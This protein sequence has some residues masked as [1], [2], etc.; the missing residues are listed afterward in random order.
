MR[1]ALKAHESMWAAPYWTAKKLPPQI[2]AM[3]TRRRSVV[4]KPAPS[5]RATV[6]VATAGVG[7]AGVAAEPG[8][9]G[10]AAADI[11]PR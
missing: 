4:P 8:A 9:A 11:H 5:G 6:G 10:T 3:R 2:I 1:V 7:T